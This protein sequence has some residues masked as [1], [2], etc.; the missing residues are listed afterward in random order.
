MTDAR[1]PSLNQRPE[2]PRR[3][4]LGFFGALIGATGA[5]ALTHLPDHPV[6]R[7]HDLPLREADFYH[8]HDLAG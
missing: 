8:R 6:A 5:L 1:D 2:A 3:R 7:R 4:F